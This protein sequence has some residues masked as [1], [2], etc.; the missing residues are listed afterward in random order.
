M[1]PPTAITE[2]RAAEL[3]QTHA[4]S[5]KDRTLAIMVLAP[6]S[7]GGTPTV[8]VELMSPGI[9]WDS[10]KML[11]KPL[12]PLTALTPEQVTDI[13]K[14]V[15]LGQSWHAYQSLKKQAEEI[16]TLR[17]QLAE[18]KQSTGAAE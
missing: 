17:R 4:K 8:G 11:L 2:S 7:V 18:L 3:L 12:V 13:Q 1:T 10:N 14:S 15:A 9:D 6:G 5:S 16:A